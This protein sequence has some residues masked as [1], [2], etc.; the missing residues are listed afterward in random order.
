MHWVEG[1]RPTRRGWQQEGGGQTDS[2][3]QEIVYAL[4]CSHSPFMWVKMLQ[5]LDKWKHF[6]S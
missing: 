6:H 2:L 5:D 3:R 1:A 4:N